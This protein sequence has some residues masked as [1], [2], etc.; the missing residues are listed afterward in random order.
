MLDRLLESLDA[1]RRAYE[2]DTEIII[3]DASDP[4]DASRIVS[5]AGRWDAQYLSGSRGVSAQRNRG[6][7][8]ARHELILFIDSDCEATSDLFREVSTVFND[9]GAVAAAGR[10]EFIGHE[11]AIFRAVRETGV[12]DAFAGFGQEGSAVPWGVTANFTVRR[13]AFFAIGGFDET[14]PPTPGGEDVDLGLRLSSGSGKIIYQPKAV[15]YHPTGPWNGLWMIIRR[16]RSY[17]RA[18]VLLMERH[19]DL[20]TLDGPGLTIPLLA[21]TIAATI[22]VSAGHS[23]WWLAVPLV[24][25]VAALTLYAIFIPGGAIAHRPRKA[26]ALLLV[27]ALDLGRQLE[28]IRRRRWRFVFCRVTLDPEQVAR[29]WSS[30]YWTWVSINLSALLTIIVAHLVSG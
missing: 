8:A 16:F 5:I 25:L 22:R 24:W 9:P 14:F 19:P 30:I 18:D 6:A 11:S 13:Q 7:A 10:V 15:V 3:T 2:G 29:D 26:L 4:G 27:Q 1:A 28:A 17:G 12:L 21:V 23:F 20:A